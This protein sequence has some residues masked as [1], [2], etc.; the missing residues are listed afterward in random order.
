MAILERVILKLHRLR[1]RLL[2]PKTYKKGIVYGPF[3]IIHP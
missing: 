2:Y 1:F 3:S